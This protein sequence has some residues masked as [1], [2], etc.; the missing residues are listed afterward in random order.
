MVYSVHFNQK[1]GLIPCN[2]LHN[3]LGQAEVNTPLFVEK[4]FIIYLHRQITPDYLSLF[5]CCHV[6]LVTKYI[7]LHN[8]T[9]L[10]ILHKNILYY[11]IIFCLIEQGTE[12]T[13]DPICQLINKLSG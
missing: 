13:N 8:I 9:A 7:L 6:R 12:L 1:E 4:K 10:V 3:K 2:L 5:S 11:F